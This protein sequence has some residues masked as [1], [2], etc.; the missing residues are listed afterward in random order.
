[1]EEKKIKEKIK[2]AELAVAEI[3]NQ[4][5]KLKAF[6]LVLSNL[7]QEGSGAQKSQQIKSKKHTSSQKRR[8]VSPQKEIRKSQLKFTEEQLKDLKKFYDQFK[9]TGRELSIFTLANF[10]N[11]IMKQ[12]KFHEGDIEYCYQQLLN[13]RT[14]SR[15]PIMNTDSIKQTLSWLVAPS[16]RKQWLESDD[17]EMYKISPGGILKYKDLEDEMG[18]KNEE[19]IE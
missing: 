17:E 9:P 11:F 19:K 4:E 1:M 18:A 8:S 10:L 13:L 5:L 12:E 3:Q 14:T 2:L 15:P 6:E 16:R 7:L